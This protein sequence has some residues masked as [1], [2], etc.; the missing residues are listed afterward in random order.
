MKYLYVN[1][2][3]FIYRLPVQRCGRYLSCRYDGGGREKRK[4]MSMRRRRRSVGGGG[5]GGGGKVEV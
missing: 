3:T 2:D 1:T 5:R 4:G